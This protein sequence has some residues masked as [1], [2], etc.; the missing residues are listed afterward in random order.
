M[1]SL[2]RDAGVLC[3]KLALVGGTFTGTFVGAVNLLALCFRTVD[4]FVDAFY[5]I[6]HI[7]HI[8]SKFGFGEGKNHTGT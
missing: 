5:I 8:K 1:L 2:S 3:S 4:A 7:H 6:Q